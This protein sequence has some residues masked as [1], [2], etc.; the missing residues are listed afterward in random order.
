M[1]LSAH[2]RVAT[3]LARRP[4]RE[5]RCGEARCQNL[6]RTARRSRAV[7]P[8]TAPKVVRFEVPP[9]LRTHRSPPGWARCHTLTSRRAWSSSRCR[10]TALVAIDSVRDEGAWSLRRWSRSAW[11]LDRVTTISTAGSGTTSCVPKCE[12]QMSASQGR[13][14]GDPEPSKGWP[15]ACTDSIKSSNEWCGNGA[16]LSDSGRYGD[17]RCDPGLLNLPRGCTDQP[18]HSLALRHPSSPRPPRVSRAPNRTDRWRGRACGTA[19]RQ[20]ALRSTGQLGR[21]SEDPFVSSPGARE[22]NAAVLTWRGAGVLVVTRL[23]D[24]SRRHRRAANAS[25]VACDVIGEQYRRH[26]GL[27]RDHRSPARV[28]LVRNEGFC[29]RDDEIATLTV[30]SSYDGRRT[31]Q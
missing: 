27:R 1:V 22:A 7:R 23:D 31:V 16:T 25:A 19:A 2:V 8:P 11:R 14:S 21:D 15:S 26:N 20:M 3:F 29:I 10:P 5:R 24:T 30:C 13:R 17:R 9:P 12:E 6:F 4:R 18:S 28:G